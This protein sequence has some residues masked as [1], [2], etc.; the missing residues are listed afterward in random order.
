MKTIIPNA[1]IAVSFCAMI[2]GC[3]TENIAERKIEKAHSHYPE[4]VA[5]YCAETYPVIDART[6]SI[7]Y[8]PGESEI[9]LDTFYAHDTFNQLS[10]KYI[11]R[12][13]RKVDTLYKLRT[14][15]IVNRA[16]EKYLADVNQKNVIVLAKAQKINNILIWVAVIMGIYTI[17]R[18]IL[19]V[20]GIRLP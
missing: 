4:I 15:Q 3:Y 10:V 14:T 19:R 12:Y 13:E 6:D 1:L 18:W 8:L 20:W 5:K 17:G 2:A 7:T 11:N 16:N 9:V